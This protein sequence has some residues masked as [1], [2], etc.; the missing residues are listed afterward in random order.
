MSLLL[1]ALKKAAE[2]K[3]QKSKQDAPEA[4][5]TDETEIDHS[6]LETRFESTHEG[7]EPGGE[8]GDGTAYRADG[9]T[10]FS[11]QASV[12]GETDFKDPVS[13][14]DE[15]RSDRTEIGSI[16]AADDKGAQVGA[17]KSGLA[18][19]ETDYTSGANVDGETDFKD[20]I[21]FEDET[22]IDRTQLGAS[23]FA[24]EDSD[25]TEFVESPG[26]D[27]ETGSGNQA[28]IED[29][30][31]IDRT[32]LE[33]T[34]FAQEDSDVTEFF[35]SPGAADETGSG[36][37]VGIED[38]TLID[39]TQLETTAFAQEDSDVT[40]FFESPGAADET[41]SGNQAGIGDETL[42]DRTQLEATAFAQ[43]DS[44]VTEFVESPG[45]A[46]ETDI[47]IPVATVDD[48][49]RVEADHETVGDDAM[50]DMVGGDS[51]D[52]TG[53]NDEDM[54]LLLVERD[55]TNLTS[56]T[57]A[58]DPRVL[59]GSPG[60]RSEE[61]DT[62]DNYSLVD[63]TRHNLRGDDVPTLAGGEATVIGASMDTQSSITR[64]GDATLTATSTRTY[65]P[66]N[67]DRTLMRLPSDDASKLFA[68]MK[69]ESDVVM[70]PDYAKKV[71]RS[72]ST[73]QRVQHYKFYSGI[74]VAILLAI[75]MFGLF[76]YQD[77]SE[78]IDMSLRPLKRDPMP[79]VI[80]PETG[81][82]IAGLFVETESH[83]RTREIIEGVDQVAEGVIAEE[84]LQAGE[85][86]DGGMERDTAQAGTETLESD[87]G[88]TQESVQ[89][90][91][92]A[93]AAS[94]VAS[95]EQAGAAQS[96]SS[97]AATA[98]EITTSSRIRQKDIWL[99]DAYQ[100]YQVG[101]DDKAMMLYN[102]VLEQ[103]PE[104]R[105]ALLARAAINIQ[106][107]NAGDAIDDYKK[108]LL[109]NPKDSLAMTS[110]LSVASISPGETESQLKLMIRDEPESPYLNFA[111]ANAYG[112]QQRWLE[113]QGH[114]FTALE[115]N[116][117]DPNYAYNL[118]VSLEHISEPGAAM[119][120]YR[121]ALDNFENGLA[122]FS[123]ELV[124]QRLEVL[125][126]P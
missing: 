107:N 113:A 45:A 41:G 76:E 96:G 104:N 14:E 34:A 87:S 90:Q 108:L 71:F 98:L 57:A 123:R 36:N 2:Q 120:Y 84:T 111:L 97:T 101:D 61:E 114:Y 28:G 106:N 25:V 77:E 50:A 115:N 38:E 10:D 88:A 43:E 73:A 78:S 99:R 72:K 22:L 67:Y 80:K 37:Q 64:P 91:P 92:G 12:D 48:L 1:D 39:R 68:G 85:R 13:F 21:S 35:E 20:Q 55:L 6:D 63:T 9:K 83:E 58:T 70:T 122:T 109:A 110:L 4:L 79:G 26:A 46:D 42:I 32:Q 105:N 49:R 24:Q 31:L 8:T 29:E 116:P 16:P 23:A 119:S 66:D 124:D 117:G 75:F 81:E 5:T 17:A 102:K 56:P 93:G 30:T 19:D 74:A 100:A 52:T 33:A 53:I 112:A 86:E 65:A 94:G 82:A 44:D 89:E 15:T 103:D 7:L 126:K 51:D 59:R 47:N 54:S 69:S 95:L 121:R 18:S 125:G 62:G 60:A 118:A 3:A 11:A 27:D 40:E